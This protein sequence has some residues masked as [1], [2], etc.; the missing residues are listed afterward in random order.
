[1]MEITVRGVLLDSLV[2]S[3]VSLCNVLVV[4]NDNAAY[5]KHKQYDINSKVV[6]HLLFDTD[7]ATQNL[8]QYSN[9]LSNVEL[10]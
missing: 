5:Q 6:H 4:Q 9:N 2:F 3:R 7:M 10:L 1:M 8:L